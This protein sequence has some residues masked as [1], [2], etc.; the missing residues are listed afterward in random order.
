MRSYVAS[1][2]DRDVRTIS[3][4]GDLAAFQRFLELCAGRTAQL[5]TYASLADDCGVSQPTAK[6]WFSILEASFIAFQLPAF[7]ARQRKR[8]VKTPKRYFQDTGLA[9]WLLGIREP[10][11]LRAH[12]LRG[13]LFE[14]WV[15]SEM[16]KHRAHRG[17]SGCLSFYRD[18]NGADLDLV[19]E[20]P[21][22][23]TVIEAKSAATPSSSLFDGVKRVYPHLGGL[24]PRCD[25]AVVYGGDEFQQ[26]TDG[27]LIPWR[28]VRSASSPTSAPL[29]HVSADGQPVARADV[30][31]L[32]PDR[33]WK[34]ARTDERGRAMLDMRPGHLPRTVF[35]ARE[36]FAAHVEPEW[37]PDER[38]LHVGLAAQPGGGSA[39]AEGV[40]PGDRIEVMV[41]GKTATI[42]LVEGERRILEFDAAEGP[43]SRRCCA[44]CPSD[45]TRQMALAERIMRRDRDV[46]RALA[47]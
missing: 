14:T 46:L 37:V 39:I 44:T 33:T 7:N 22:A 34:S 42:D 25:V 36:G 16:L 6:A 3:N 8:L 30:L 13:A 2:V 45:A 19:V 38:T 15:A 47:K 24:R 29:V 28:L 9:C 10:E 40:T 20:E 31:A 32:S 11:Q 35:V 41:K 4:V 27:R 23:L 5:L 26:R 18:R 43:D 21:D 17:G 12:P 1:Y